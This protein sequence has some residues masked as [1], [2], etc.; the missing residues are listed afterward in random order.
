MNN[1]T[2][3]L[4]PWLKGGLIRPRHAAGATLLLETAYGQ[5]AASRPPEEWLLLAILLKT[6]DDEHTCLDLREM[7]RYEPDAANDDEWDPLPFN[8]F[9]SWH[10]VASRLP[11]LVASATIVGDGVSDRPLVLDSPRLYIARMYGDEK[12]VAIELN[13]LQSRNRLHVLFG[14]PGSG[15]TWKTAG[16]LV[17]RVSRTNGDATPKIE[18]AAPTGKAAQRMSEVLEETMEKMKSLRD[19]EWEGRKPISAAQIDKAKERLKTVQSKTIHKLLKFNPSADN[20]YQMSRERPLDCTLLIVDESSM[21]S[22]DLLVHVLMAL[23][24]GAELWLVGDPDQLASVGAGTVFADIRSAVRADRLTGTELPGNRR[25]SNPRTRDLIATVKQVSDDPGEEKVREHL[26]EH[27]NRFFDILR[28]TSQGCEYCVHFPAAHG[29]KPSPSMQLCAETGKHA[30]TCLRGDWQFNSECLWTNELDGRRV[31]AID[32]IDPKSQD[33]LERINELLTEII[34]VAKQRVSL[35]QAR[36]S[37][38]LLRAELDVPTAL[39]DVQ[40]LCVH[41]RGPLGVQGINSRVRAALGGSAQEHWF[42]GR[43][44][45]ITR[46]DWRTGLFN[47]DTGVVADLAGERVLVLSEPVKREP[48]PVARIADHELN[49]AMT[50]HKSQGSEYDHA[51]ILLPAVPSRICTREMLYTAI[52]RTKRRLTIVGAEEVIRHMLAT[53]VSRASGLGDRL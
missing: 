47:G 29:V 45:M 26:S 3:P 34:D 32:W 49:F 36:D 12:I 35:A 6:P 31:S 18:L 48:V 51:V 22:L 46:N 38:L 1:S 17:E 43:P 28:G 42:L 23:P 10:G 52:S 5:S 14:G 21:L 40:V 2:H 39:P 7:L 50:V 20:R 53:P 8:D 37:A 15:K 4:A 24:D 16:D 11:E 19:D 13:K 44:V 33:G 9:E 27:T 25:A 30:A 41:R